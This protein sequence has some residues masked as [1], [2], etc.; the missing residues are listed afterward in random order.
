MLHLAAAQ[1]TPQLTW[2]LVQDARDLLQYEFM[3]NAFLAGSIVALVAGV[4]GYFVVLR[5]LAFGIEALA[6]GGFAGA[7]GAVLIN[8][9][10]LTG[11]LGYM[12]V[13]GL[14]I[15]IL[16]DRLRGRDVGIGA[17]LTFSLALGSLF[18]AISTKQAGLATNILFG[19]VLGIS[20]A[21]VQFL[22]GFSALILVVLVVLYRP[23]FFASVDPDAA[24]ARGVPVKLI[25]I[26]FSILLGVAIAAATEVVGVLLIFALLILPA[27]TAQHFTPRPG[28]AI[29]A[30]ALIGL[31]C[32]WFGLSMGFYLPYPPSFFITAA[33]FGLYVV[34]QFLPGVGS[35][36]RRSARVHVGLHAPHPG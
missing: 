16:G 24:E 21:D 9:D 10:V 27:A 20:T 8:M 28:R 12:M 11:L 4:M 13:A 34:S 7:T 36:E 25:G 3:R 31:G 29:L 23:L 2:N 22:V 33:A 17:V 6:H 35:A 1:V 5:H 19:N 18:L 32:V 15:G 14:V 26:V 30:A